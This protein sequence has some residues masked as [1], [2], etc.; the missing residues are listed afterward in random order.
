M[1]RFR[2]ALVVVA[3]WDFVSIGVTC[4]LPTFATLPKGMLVE[5]LK[6]VENFRLRL[7]Q[8]LCYIWLTSVELLLLLKLYYFHLIFSYLAWYQMSCM[9]LAANFL[10]IIICHNLFNIYNRVRNIWLKIAPLNLNLDQ[11]FWN[12][13][14]KFIMGF[15]VTFT[16]NEV[17]TKY[18]IRVICLF[19]KSNLC[20]LENSTLGFLQ[21]ICV[22]LLPTNYILSWWPV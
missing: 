11:I 15:T 20:L 17:I 7:S 2:E 9:P 14:H 4:P 3:D 12:F 6:Y 8:F 18:I 5:C 10:V 16:A 21:I 22:K 1:L 19:G 13:H